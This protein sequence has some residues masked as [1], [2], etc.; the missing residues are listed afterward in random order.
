MR[1]YPSLDGLRCYAI[2][3][4]VWHHAHSGEVGTI[5]LGRVGVDLFFVISGFLITT[6]LLREQAEASG[7]AIGRF[8]ARRSLRI[9]PLYYLVLGVY[10]LHA[11]FVREHGPVRDHFLRSIP[12][13][14]TYTTN[15]FVDFDVPHGVVFG[16]AWSLTVEEQFYLVWPWVLRVRSLVVPVMFMLALILAREAAERGILP[17]EAGGF[18]ARWLVNMATP[19]CLGALLAIGMH[20]APTRPWFLDLLRLR[21]LAPLSFIVLVAAVARSWPTL[22]VHVVMVVMVGACVAGSTHGLRLFTDSFPVRHVGLV[23]YGIYLLH[24]PIVG[25]ARTVLPHQRG[26]AFVIAFGLSIVA[27]TVSY[28]YIEQPFLRLKESFRGSVVRR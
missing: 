2:A 5:G 13:H 14:A 15:L 28:R 17:L 24:G 21:F 12:A 16:C 9:F 6:L 22:L 4:V 7:I 20:A 8:Y 19:I 27:A 1:R 18:A 26:W 23:S 10:V 25:A 3:L 11:F